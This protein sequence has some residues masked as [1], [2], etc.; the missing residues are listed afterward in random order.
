MIRGSLGQLS[1]LAKAHKVRA[2][3]MLLIGE[4]ANRGSAYQDAPIL[5][6]PPDEAVAASA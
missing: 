3:A 6:D 4:V 5:Q 1:L 2:P